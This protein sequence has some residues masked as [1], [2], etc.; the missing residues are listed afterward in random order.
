MG[1]NDVAVFASW[2]P[3]LAIPKLVYYKYIVINPPG[4]RS[5][6][7]R[8]RDSRN[9]IPGI[10]QLRLHSGN[11]KSQFGW[12]HCQISFLRN[13]RNGL[14]S[15]G[16]RAEYQGDSKDLGARLPFKLH[17]WDGR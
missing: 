16:F 13:S 11:W 9:G 12:P 6:Q 8:E 1:R 5:G 3:D 15:A 7:F 2:L 17:T 10:C 4:F 14:D